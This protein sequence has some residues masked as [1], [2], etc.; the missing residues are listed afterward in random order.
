[1]TDEPTAPSAWSGRRRWIRLL[2]AALPIGAIAVFVARSDTARIGAALSSVSMPQI[3]ALLAL[4][5]AAAVVGALRFSFVV[6]TAG[7]RAEYRACLAALVESYGFMAL[8]AGEVVGGA[9]RWRRMH[10]FGLSRTASVSVLLAER[11]LDMAG[12]TTVA[13]VLSAYADADAG[14]NVAKPILSFA[15]LT[16]VGAT[17]TWMVATRLT[18]RWRPG[19][20]T[21]S[22]SDGWR[23]RVAD[24]VAGLAAAGSD[25][26]GL[27]RAAAG[28][29]LLVAIGVATQRFM[30]V[31]MLGFSSIPTGRVLL[32]T[33]LAGVAGLL[34]VSPAGIGVKEGVLVLVL[35][36]DGF[37]SGVA[38]AYTALL[39]ACLMVSTAAGIAVHL[40]RTPKTAAR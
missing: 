36:R 39:V 12:W 33:S 35:S 30:L 11:L 10:A 25:F 18:K 28:T 40:L 4:L 32:A 16:V 19:A 21:A 9:V 7:G 26:R 38:L 22:A 14:S 29:A 20:E 37:D 13:F 2:A 23:R 34:P 3:F 27:A 6:R 1:L 24:A 8:P 31:D 17:A 5:V 15:A